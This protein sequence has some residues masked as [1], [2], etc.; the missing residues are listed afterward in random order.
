M[1]SR[2][3][4]GAVLGKAK[5]WPRPAATDVINKEQ[6]THSNDQGEEKSK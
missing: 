1:V 6:I 4:I 2:G 3:Q 5:N